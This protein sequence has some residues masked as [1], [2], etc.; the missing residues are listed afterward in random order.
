[1]GR[2]RLAQSHHIHPIR[3]PHSRPQHAGVFAGR[4]TAATDNTHTRRKLAG[5][6]APVPPCPAPHPAAEPA[7][8]PVDGLRRGPTCGYTAPSFGRRPEPRML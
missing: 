8:G 1:M 4:H 3:H 2:H 6:S 7:N 5:T